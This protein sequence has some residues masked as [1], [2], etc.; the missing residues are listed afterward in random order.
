[1]DTMLGNL[2][3]AIAYLD[4]IIIASKNREE[5]ASHIKQVLSWIQNYGFNVKEDKCEFFL[6]KIKYL[7]HISD[8]DGW[9]P[10][11]DRATAIRE[12][13]AA[14]NIVQLQSFCLENY[15]QHFISN[16]HKLCAPLSQL[17]KKGHHIARYYFK[18]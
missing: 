6:Q 17:L 13:P 12:M 2:D 14:E 1:M 9:R 15:Y 3:T 8:K 10:N 5:H 7:R 4:D 11:P 16:M 18:K